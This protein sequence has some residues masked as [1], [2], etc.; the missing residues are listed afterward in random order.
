MRVPLTD[1][2]KT[3]RVLV[4]EDNPEFANN[5][6]GLSNCK[7]TLASDMKTAAKL[8]REQEFD[9]V[10][11]D[12]NFPTREGGQAKRQDLPIAVHCLYH[13]LP[14]AVVTRGD[15]F[16]EQHVNST[17]IEIYTF[18]PSDLMVCLFKTGILKGTA[19]ENKFSIRKAGEDYWG[20]SKKNTIKKKALMGVAS[21][22][23]EIWKKAI[24]ML[25]SSLLE[26]ERIGVEKPLSEILAK[27][28][29]VVVP[30]GGKYHGFPMPAKAPPKLKH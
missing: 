18:T 7:V 30:M 13:N 15:S 4:I 26:R 12:L 21:K 10:L 5:A 3:R 8:M 9:M 16:E 11:S 6:L 22:D 27:G 24:E 19:W 25:E 17:I 1:S 2:L 23:T 20:E 14:L 28:K 29:R